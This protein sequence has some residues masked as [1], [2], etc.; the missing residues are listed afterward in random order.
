M[1]LQNKIEMKNGLPF[2]KSDLQ[3]IKINDF[4]TGG[5]LGTNFDQSVFATLI[6]SDD[7]FKALLNTPMSRMLRAMRNAS[8]NEGTL[9]MI[10]EEVVNEDGT[11]DLA[12]KNI[13]TMS[14]SPMT[15]KPDDCCVVPGELQV[16]QDITILKPLCIEQ[17][18]EGITLMA[19]QMGMPRNS[20]AYAAYLALLKETGVN[21]DLPTQEAFDQL[22]LIAQFVLLNMLTFLNGLLDVEQNGNIIR[23][24]NGLMQQYADPDIYTIDGSLGILEAFKQ[25]L[26]RINIVGWEGF[27]QGFFAADFIAFQALQQE[28]V[29][30][31]N[32]EYPVGWK[33]VE[34]T[35]TKNG[36]TYPK[37]YYYFNGIP[38]LESR[39]I[40]VPDTM[41]GNIYFVPPTEGVFSAIPLDFPEQFIM[42]EW[43][44]SEKDT[45][46]IHWDRNKVAYPTCWSE[47]VAI[48]NFGGVFNANPNHLMVITAIKSVCGVDAYKGVEGLINPNSLAP[49]IGRAK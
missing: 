6:E 29:K 13:P 46:F 35:E 18:E 34:G 8:A 24:F 25:S 14:F 38:V 33:V 31:D 42:N 16:C 48:T 15:A 27:Q 45:A 23:R 43:K 11:K 19:R 2:V 37:N 4:F 7:V 44:K 17:C 10:W 5:Q 21:T 47:C 49:Y 1:K 3:D 12:L 28:I 20:V 30:K 26:C 40:T 9:P 22:S 32:G 41:V 39:N 36:V